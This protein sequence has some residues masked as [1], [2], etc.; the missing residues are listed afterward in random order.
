MKIPPLIYGTAWKK[1]QTVN[2]VEMAIR[3]GFRGID[4]ACQPK[5]YH[6]AGV[7]EALMRLKSLGIER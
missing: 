5:H 6:E 3:S 1:E 7:G 4:T 2:L